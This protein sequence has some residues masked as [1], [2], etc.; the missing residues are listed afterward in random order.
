MIQLVFLSLSFSFKLCPPKNLNIEKCWHSVVFAFIFRNLAMLQSFST[1]QKSLNLFFPECPSKTEVFRAWFYFI[2]SGCIPTL[3]WES[4]YGSSAILTNVDKIWSLITVVCNVLSA[5]VILECRSTPT[6]FPLFIKKRSGTPMSL[7][8]R[9]GS[10]TPSS[11][12]HKKSALFYRSFFVFF[13]RFF[14]LT[15]IHTWNWKFTRNF[16]LS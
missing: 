10:G 11:L 12:F 5:L 9:K 4:L 3:F 16:M 7:L 15:S 1:F 14:F 2:Y 13:F 8:L 6:L